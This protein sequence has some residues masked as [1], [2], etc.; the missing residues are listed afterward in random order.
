LLK[1][2]LTMSEPLE[3]QVIGFV[4]EETGHPVENI[5]LETSLFGD[6][7]ADGEDGMAFIQ[8]SSNR[9]DVDIAMFV[10]RKYFGPEAGYLFPISLCPCHSDGCTSGNACRT[11][12]DS[13][14]GRI[15]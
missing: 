5:T 11:D 4:V 1:Q 2:T 6:L 15:S 9:F 3:R 12:F 10:H 7:G 8:K 14:F 13:G